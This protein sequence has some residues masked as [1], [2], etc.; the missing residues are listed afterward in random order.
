[1]VLAR[2]LEGKLKILKSAG[3]KGK[4]GE[5]WVKGQP[6]GGE[7]VLGC[8]GGQNVHAGRSMRGLAC[9]KEKK[10]KKKKK[11]RSLK[12]GM[13]VVGGVGQRLLENKLSTTERR[14]MGRGHNWGHS[15]KAVSGQA[16]FFFSSFKAGREKLFGKKGWVG[17]GKGG[18]VGVGVCVFGV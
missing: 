13:R 10:K 7:S 11:K 18:G 5:A 14:K 3:L 9:E 12:P 15:K 6:G 1:V 17:Y 4:K 16:G 2:S 8:L